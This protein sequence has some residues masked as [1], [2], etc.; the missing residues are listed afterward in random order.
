MT[1]VM[2]ERSA[3]LIGPQQCRTARV[4][5]IEF[6]RVQYGSLAAKAERN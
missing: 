6:T 1:R 2:L 3:Q 4:A 5:E